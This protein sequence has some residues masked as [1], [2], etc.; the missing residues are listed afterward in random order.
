MPNKI[1]HIA[2]TV[3][4][5][6]RTLSLFQELFGPV[7]VVQKEDDGHD[8]TLVRL[9]GIWFVLVKADVDRSRTGDH[10]AFSVS[11]VELQELSDKLRKMDLEFFLAR[12]DTAIYFFDYDNH[13]FELDTTDLDAIQI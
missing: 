13:V 1:S 11:K 5:P 7:T 2:L 4:D 6:R 12:S 9:G 10:I 8:E 3:K